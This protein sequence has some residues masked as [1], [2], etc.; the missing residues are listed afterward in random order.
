MDGI[1]KGLRQQFPSSSGKGMIGSM[2]Y[3]IS[4]NAKSKPAHSAN[5]Y[6]AMHRVALEK[7]VIK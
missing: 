5:L 1:S 4:K 2:N 7:G 6:E 3:M